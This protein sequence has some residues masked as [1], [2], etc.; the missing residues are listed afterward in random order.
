[1]KTDIEIRQDIFLWLSTT[2]LKETVTGE[3]SMTGRETDKEDVCISVLASEGRQW[4]KVYVNVNIYVKDIHAN[5]VYRENTLRT[6]TLAKL[7]DTIMREH[8]GKGWMCRMEKQSVMEV[9]ATNE[10]LINNKLFYQVINE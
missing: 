7:C 10:H 6:G 4:Q 9:S 5:E 2:D 3:I 8:H 1:M